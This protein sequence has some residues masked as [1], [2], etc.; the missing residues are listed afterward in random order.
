MVRSG[1][2]VIA[3]DAT[4]MI[5]RTLIAGKIALAEGREVSLDEISL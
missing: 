5:M 1:Q 3:P 2:P 4:L